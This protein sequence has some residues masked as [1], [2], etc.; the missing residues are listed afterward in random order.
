MNSNIKT[1]NEENLRKEY[2]R[3]GNLFEEK[4]LKNGKPHR[5]DG[6]AIIWYYGNGSIKKEEYWLEDMVY[7]NIFQWSVQVGSY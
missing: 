1:K 5:E 4:Y 7:D 6:P 2:Y 3:N